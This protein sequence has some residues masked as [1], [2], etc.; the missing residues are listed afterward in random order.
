MSRAAV[1]SAARLLFRERGDPRPPLG[2]DPITSTSSTLPPQHWPS[3]GPSANPRVSAFAAFGLAS[4]ACAMAIAFHSSVPP[5]I[6]PLKV[7]SG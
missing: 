2:L 5:P 3:S 1:V 4:A 7:A 6:V